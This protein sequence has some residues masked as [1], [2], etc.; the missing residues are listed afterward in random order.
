[1]LK[2]RENASRGCP[3]CFTSIFNHRGWLQYE[4]KW[5]LKNPFFQPQ[6]PIENRQEN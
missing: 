1:M 4:K 2:N 3:T 6:G 5:I